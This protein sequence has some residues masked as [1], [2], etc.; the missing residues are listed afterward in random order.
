MSETIRT[1]MTPAELR[2]RGMEL[3][4][5]CWLPVLVTLALLLLPT[6]GS[7]ALLY[8]GTP[9]APATL[10][11]LAFLSLNDSGTPSTGR[12][13]A[14]VVVDLAGSLLLAPVLLLG[15]NKGLLNRLRGTKCTL[16]CLFAGISR[17][18]TAVALEV[19]TLLR[20]IGYLLV[21][22][23]ARGLVSAIPVLGPIVGAIGFVVFTY[24]VMLRY[25]L[26]DVHLADDDEHGCTASDCLDYSIADVY[27]F[28]PTRLLQTLWP[29]LLP[30]LACNV[31]TEF[32]PMS[33][34]L[35]AATCAMELLSSA[36]SVVFCLSVYAYLHQTPLP[37]EPPV[38]AGLSRARALAAGEDVSGS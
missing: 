16:R 23:F 24:W 25:M 13:I 4:R 2:S 35:F 22:G 31:L 30:A 14:S 7:A 9:G 12:I 28:T 1:P 19:L 21:G 29:A 15:L 37:A 33:A 5:E 10:E 32:L 26:A 11:D 34:P 36:L 3:L 20:I 17:W 8:T 38:P 6:L 18:K 27:S